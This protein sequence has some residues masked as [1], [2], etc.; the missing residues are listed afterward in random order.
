MSIT[1][2]A[3]ADG[4]QPTK[5]GVAI[6]D[7]VTGLFGAV[8]DPGRRCS[9]ATRRRG[10]R[11]PRPADRRLAPRVD[12]RRPRQ[13]GAERVRDRRGAGPAGN[14][15]P[16]IVPYETFATA[17]G[18]LA[19]AVG[20]E[21]QWPRFCEAIG[22][23]G[24]AEDPR[25]A[26]NADRVAHRDDAPP[27]PRRRGSRAGPTAEWIAALDAGGHPVRADQRRPRG[28]R[29]AAGRRRAG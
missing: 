11:R 29:V 4:G 15:H 9:P 22:L 14:A 25:F 21:R 12:P 2:D 16:N 7:V 24:L 26:T 20:S 8:G 6:S 5:V 13:P 27:A 28:V 19:V 3:D 17:D 18:E 10:P 1:G 23:P